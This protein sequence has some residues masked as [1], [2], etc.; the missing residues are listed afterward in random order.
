VRH[1][2]PWTETVEGTRE[3]MRRPRGRRVLRAWPKVARGPPW[4]EL[5]GEGETHAVEFITIRF[6]GMAARNRPMGR[7][8]ASALRKSLKLSLPPLGSRL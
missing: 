8:A 6:G 4:S 5:E 2:Y 3:A 7:K 1:G